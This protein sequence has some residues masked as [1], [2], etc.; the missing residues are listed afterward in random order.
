LFGG[1][2]KVNL[3]VLGLLAVLVVA[4]AD[5]RAARGR[6]R[7]LVGTTGGRRAPQDSAARNTSANILTPD[8]LWKSNP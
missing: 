8:V 1:P 3:R 4:A 5:S 2:V 7:S 6:A